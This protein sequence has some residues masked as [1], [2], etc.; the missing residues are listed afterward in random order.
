[1]NNVNMRIVSA[2]I[3]TPDGKREIPG[4]DVLMFDAQAQAISYRER[5]T[6]AER[7]ITSV[8]MPILVVNEV[9]SIAR[10]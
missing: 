6:G 7:I 8:A 2:T 4:E 3:Y 5:S 10:V 9:S 1:M